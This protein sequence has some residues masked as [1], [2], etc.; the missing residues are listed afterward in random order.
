MPS[1]TFNLLSVGCPIM[2]I[3]EPEA[4]LSKLVDKYNVGKHFRVNEL[5]Q[6]V[7][8]IQQLSQEVVVHQSLSQNALKASLEFGPD[9]AKKFVI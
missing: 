4:E 7:C 8:F 3:A 5:D 1:K 2:A 9:N 6:M